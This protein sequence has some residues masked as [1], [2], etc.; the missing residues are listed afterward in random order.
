MDHQLE[1][2]GNSNVTTFIE[3]RIDQQVLCHHVD[4]SDWRNVNPASGWVN[5]GNSISISNTAIQGWKFE[6]WTGTVTGSYSGSENSTTVNVQTP[7]TENATF[8]VGLTIGTSSGGS[9]SYTYGNSGSV[10][11]TSQANVYVPP[12][13]VVTLNANPSSLLY[14]LSSWSGAVTGSSTQYSVTVNSP[15]SVEA[16]FGYNLVNIGGIVAVIVIAVVG[17]AVAMTRRKPA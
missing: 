1:C 6:F 8:Y 12:G 2:N 13:T 15:S 5:A 11:I 3:F 7:I 10:Q 9:V 17:I 16:Q 14:K 4:T